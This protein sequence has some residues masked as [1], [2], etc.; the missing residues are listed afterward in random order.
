MADET[1]VSVQTEAT[2]LAMVIEAGL[3]SKTPPIAGWFNLDPNSYGAF[4]PRYKKMP[5]D[6]ITKKMQM[7]KGMLVDE[8]S[9]LAIEF[10][11]TKDNIDRFGEAIYRSLW[12]HNGGTGQSLFRPTAVTSAH[13]SVPGQGALVARTLVFARGFDRDENVG[14]KMVTSGSTSTEIPVSGLVAE[15][16]PPDNVTLEVAGYRGAAGTLRLDTDGNL[17]SVGGVDLTT[18]GLNEFQYV[19]I[20]GEDAANRFATPEYFGAA[21]I[22]ADGIAAGKLTFDRRSWDVTSRAELDLGTLATQLDTIV[23]AITAGAA[24]NSITVA[25]VADGTPGVKAELDLDVPSTNV[26][27][28]IRAKAAG[29]AGNLITVE[30]VAGA[31]SAAGVL[32]E[33]G[34]HVKIQFKATATATTVSDLET[35][36]ATSTL[37]EVK[38]P[39]TGATSLA[40][41]DAFASVAL[42][43]GA[44]GDAADVTEVGDAV[45]LHYTPDET[46]VAQLE[47]AIN[48]LS[49]KIR[50]KLA[51]TGSSVLQTGDDDFTATALAGGTSGDDD[52]AG[53]QID[54]L[55]TRYIRNVSMDHA[56]YRRPSICFELTYPDLDGESAMYQYMLGNL[57]DEWTWNIGV[58]TKATINASF[59]GTKSLP[60]TATRKTGPADALNPVTQGGISTSTDLQRLRL[61][62]VDELGITSDFSSVK[63]MTKNNVGPEKQVG[64]LGAAIM[65]HGTHVATF[66]GDVIFA[67]SETIN[68]VRSNVTC[69]FDVLMRN[70]E[71]GVLLDVQAMTLDSGDMKMERNKSVKVS[72]KGT[73][74]EYA[75][76]GSTQ[77]LS[78]FAYLPAVPEDFEGTL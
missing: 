13:Y 11:V 32:T 6:P 46:T 45:T 40:A 43:G 18:L 38:T 49:T 42:A 22:A 58:T 3:G 16:S 74:F 39:G 4:G 54:L 34:T 70:P 29:A 19:Y 53:K 17:I 52:G 75:K 36:I 57:V 51:G 14:L 67:R 24:G 69:T 1:T 78:L 71:F 20:G 62:R 2:N 23:E 59:I 68:A 21:R 25:S 28:V 26:D 15:A 30:F 72:S 61:D 76:A 48:S 63:L 5:R 56:D 9:G 7:Q 50:V 55:F 66:E 10:D 31:G 41:G 65:N 47:A 33:V 64:K 73:G 12:K 35:L 8:D 27:T 37:I 60:I 44:D 77:S